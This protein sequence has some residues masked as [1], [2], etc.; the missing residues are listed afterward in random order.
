MKIDAL[1]HD[2]VSCLTKTAIGKNGLIRKLYFIDTGKW[3]EFYKPDD[4]G[5]HTPFITAALGS[6]EFAKQQY[7]LWEKRSIDGIPIPK[8]RIPLA[9]LLEAKN[10]DDLLHG[11]YV[12]YTTTKDDFFLKEGVQLSRKAV[13]AFKMKN[14]AFSSVSIPFLHLKLP[15][16][17]S[18]LK[19][20][21][22]FAP[23]SNLKYYSEACSNGLISEKLVFFGELAGD[24]DLIAAAKG[25]IDA[26]LETKMFRKYGVFPDMAFPKDSTGSS[27]MKTNTN[28]GYALLKLK[29]TNYKSALDKL[30]SSIEKIYDEKTGIVNAFNPATGKK[31]EPTLIPV[32]AYGTLLLMAGRKE[33]AA[34]LA[35][36]TITLA[37]EN[38]TLE[39]V[40][41]DGFGDFCV[42]L[43]RVDEGHNWK[44]LLEGMYK[45]FVDM[46]YAGKGMWKDHRSGKIAHSKYLGGVLKYLLAYKAYLSNDTRMFTDHLPLLEDR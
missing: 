6:P 8:H 24:K 42:F 26:W 14:G 23:A 41:D 36:K 16:G 39:S 4:F 29:E 19:P 21:I 33:K 22:L 2:T 15:E 44:G 9:P 18:A 20:A 40:D 7:S 13:K 25:C 17:C 43:M 12:N 32:Q 45:E 34:N 28:M 35:Q 27:L 31:G 5:D 3:Y 11:L 1:I 30:L 10:V 38:G 37:R 46:Y